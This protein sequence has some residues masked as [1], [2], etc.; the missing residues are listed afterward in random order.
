[1]RDLMNNIDVKRGISP[2]AAVADNTPFVSEILDVQ[3]L[4]SATFLALTG[5]L[6]TAGASFTTLLEHGNDSGLSDAAPVPDDEL[7]GTEALA[8]FDGNADDSVFKIGY[9]GGKHYVRATVTP[10]SN[11]GNAFVSGV[12]VTE[13]Q[14][15]PAA[16]PPA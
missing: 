2:A 10:A 13:P 9:I 4:K 15:R 8:S 7:V 3:G 5:A 12:W 14:I 11:A 1:M 6:A 16:N